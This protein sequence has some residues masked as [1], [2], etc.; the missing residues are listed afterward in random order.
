MTS[1]EG[2]AYLGRLQH[3]GIKLGLENIATLC[4]ALGHPQNRFLS[5]H[6]AGTN[7][8]GSVSAI[9]AGIMKEHGLRT[10]LYTS[11]HLARVEERICVDGESIPPRRFLEDRKSVV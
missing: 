1:S 9:L 10:G 7:G 5:I 3:F 8:K 6:V 4:A 11:P 2:R